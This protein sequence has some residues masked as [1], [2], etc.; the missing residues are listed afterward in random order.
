VTLLKSRSS[1]AANARSAAEAQ[2]RMSLNRMIIQDR[3]QADGVA[4]IL[5]T[6]S[7]V[8]GACGKISHSPHRRWCRHCSEGIMTQSQEQEYKRLMPAIWRYYGLPDSGRPRRRPAA[9]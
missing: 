1:E 8:C 2:G 9:S 7:V 4:S 5:G 6:G 3:A